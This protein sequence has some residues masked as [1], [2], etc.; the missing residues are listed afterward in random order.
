MTVPLSLLKAMDMAF[1][2]QVSPPTTPFGQLARTPLESITICRLLPIHGTVVLLNL[3]L[4]DIH[5]SR[6]EHW[7]TFKKFPSTFISPKSYTFLA[8]LG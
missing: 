5:D 2:Y 3:P 7:V 8:A 1:Q 4:Q 6:L